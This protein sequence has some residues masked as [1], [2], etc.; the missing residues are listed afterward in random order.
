MNGYH[1]KTLKLNIM[2]YIR[3]V[4]LGFDVAVTEKNQ[5]DVE[6]LKNEIENLINTY[7]DINGNNA[8][9]ASIGSGVN[10]V[11]YDMNEVNEHFL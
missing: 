9:F 5:D 10:G 3:V 2:K 4:Q 11:E 7:N 8:E 6:N 1:F